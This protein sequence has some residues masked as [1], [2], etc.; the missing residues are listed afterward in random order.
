MLTLEKPDLHNS[1]FMVANDNTEHTPLLSTDPPINKSS[2]ATPSSVIT[3][4]VA[5]PSI[6]GII[7]KQ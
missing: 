7:Y 2:A 5:P 1:D 4:S 3:V 6:C